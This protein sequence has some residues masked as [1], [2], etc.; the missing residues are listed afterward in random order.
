[1]CKCVSYFQKEDI[2]H[3]LYM[4]QRH[5]LLNKTFVKKTETICETDVKCT[6]TGVNYVSVDHGCI[7]SSD[8]PRRSFQVAMWSARPVSPAK[9]PSFTAFI[10]R[11]IKSNRCWTPSIT[12]RIYSLGLSFTEANKCVISFLYINLIM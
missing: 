5:V 8:V 12:K 6:I 9:T 2:M 1:V 10:T 7:R 3:S 11:T 4:S